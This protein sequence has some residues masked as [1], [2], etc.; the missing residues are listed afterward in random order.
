MPIKNIPFTQ[1]AYEKMFSDKDKLLKLRE[2]VIIRLQ[3]AREMGDLS[4]NGA[5]KYAKFELGNVN[6]K[7]RQLEYLLHFGF[8][9]KSNDNKVIGFGNQVTLVSARKEYHFLLVGKHESDPAQQKLSLESPIGKAILNK[10]AGE[11]VQVE[12]PSGT[13]SYLIKKIS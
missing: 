13:V 11:T 3:T 8:V 5:Y 1:I 9:Q 12:T 4:E 7:L 6:R 10:K 2:E